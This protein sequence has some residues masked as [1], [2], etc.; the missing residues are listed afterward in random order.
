VLNYRLIGMIFDRVYN[1]LDGDFDLVDGVQYFLD[2]N[3]YFVFGWRMGCVA[4]LLDVSDESGM[5]VGGVL[6]CADCA[7]RFNQS[8]VAFNLVAVT[9]LVLFLDVVS[10]LVLHGILELVMGRFLKI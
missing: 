8:V 2:G 6:H 4:G 10:V 7:V 5:L 1:L 3:S 9:F